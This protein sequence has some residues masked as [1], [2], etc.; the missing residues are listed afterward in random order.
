MAWKA[1]VA[2]KTSDQNSGTFTLA[3][4]FYD[5]A[6]P[7]TMIVRREITVPASATLAEIQV[8]VRAEGVRERTKF[9]DLKVLDGRINV[10][11]EVVV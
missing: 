1:K 9:N 10:G 7:A 3:I 11:D 5:T 6:D 8:L 2:Q 4:D